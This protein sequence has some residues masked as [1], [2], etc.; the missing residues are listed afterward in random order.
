MCL[1]NSIIFCVFHDI[2]RLG[3][4][5]LGRCGYTFSLFYQV[6]GIAVQF[7]PRT[8]WMLTN[9]RLGPEVMAIFIIS[10]ASSSSGLGNPHSVFPVI[11]INC[12][13]HM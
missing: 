1:T 8:K 11:P 12:T 2:Q 6:L 10:S 4:P 5:D 3:N 9:R 7:V 13:T